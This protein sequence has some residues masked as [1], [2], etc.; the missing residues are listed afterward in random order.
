[1]GNSWDYYDRLTES[2]RRYRPFYPNELFDFTKN[3]K[4]L[5]T[6]AFVADIGCGT[7]QLSRLL[8]RHGLNVF[9]VEPN[10]KMLDAAIEDLGSPHF[11]PKLGSAEETTI[12]NGTV[13]AIFVGNAF[14]WFDHD[15]CRREFKRIAQKDSIVVLAWN[16]ERTDE[17][18]FY[19]EFKKLWHTYI[20]K[21]Q[22]FGG[23]EK[24]P[25][26]SYVKDFF[27]NGY[28]MKVFKNSQ[29]IDLNGFIG[30][31]KSFRKAPQESDLK[32]NDMIKLASE[33]FS[34]YANNN[35]VII[36]YDTPVIIGRIN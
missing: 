14:H 30:L 7:G 17:S 31:I 8:I 10:R 25:L 13:E 36:F 23:A 4:D 18:P 2:Y 16:L 28:Q 26:P 1:M 32:Y 9:G 34:K 20:D 5:R 15:R 6:E 35:K 27:E 21:D 22:N 33:I 3:I 19:T 12:L 29:V 11:F 24:N